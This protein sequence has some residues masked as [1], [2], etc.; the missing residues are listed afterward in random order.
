MVN[1]SREPRRELV[2]DRWYWYTPWFGGC[3]KLKYTGTRREVKGV[4]F[5][6]FEGTEGQCYFFSDSEV[7]TMDE[8]L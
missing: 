1:M 5:E 4:E 7:N 3:V 8:V 6:F 2:K